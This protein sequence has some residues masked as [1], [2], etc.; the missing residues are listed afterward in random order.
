MTSYEAIEK[1]LIANHIPYN[2]QEML[3]KHTT[4]Q[5]GGPCAFFCRP[6]S[7]QQLGRLLDVLRQRRLPF[8]VLGCGSN[9]LFRDEGFDGVIIHLGGLM[10]H[11]RLEGD[12]LVA[13]AAAPL[14]KVCEAAQK[15]GLGGLEFAYGIPGSVGGAVYM[16][17]GAFGGEMKGVVD[18]VTFLDDAGKKRTL[19]GGELEFGYRKSTFQQN[20]WLILE[21][22]FQLTAAPKGTIL[23]QMQAN[24]EYRQ[25]KQPLDYPSAGSAFKRPEGAYAAALI[26]ECGLRGYRVGNAAI[27]TKHCGFIVNLGGATCEEV[28]ELADKVA[29]TVHDKTGFILEKEIRVVDHA[30]VNLHE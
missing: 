11:I 6:A 20:K 7:E 13:G 26:D 25:K 30:R 22:T 23:Q 16:N 5:I 17:A 10:G 14:F 15:N 27:S 3:S 12:R 21:T 9:I 29:E 4:F 19:L 8:F 28:L 18:S 2:K 24:T 1:E